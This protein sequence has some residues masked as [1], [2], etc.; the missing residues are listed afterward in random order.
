MFGFR[1]AKCFGRERMIYVAP[2]TSILDQTYEKFLKIFNQFDDGYLHLHHSSFSL[3]NKNHEEQLS[4]YLSSSNWQNPFI[5]TTSVQFFDSLFSN[6]PSTCRKL[7]NI[8]NSVILLDEIQTF[9]LKHIK[10]IITHIEFLIK[11]CNCSFVHMS[12]TQPYYNELNIFGSNKT[13]IP[14]ICRDVEGYS[15]KLERVCFSYSDKSIQFEEL[16]N[17]IDNYNQYIVVVNTKKDAVILYEQLK[18]KNKTNLFHLS[19]SMYPKHR[20]DSIKRIKLLL[21]ENKPCILISTQLIEVGV[22]IDFPIGTRILGS[23]DSIIQTAG[24]INRN[25]KSPSLPVVKILK[26][27]TTNKMSPVYASYTHQT[28]LFIKD[29]LLKNDLNWLSPATYKEYYKRLFE[30]KTSN[31]VS[32]SE[33][34]YKNC[35]GFNFKTIS[36]KFNMIDNHTVNVIIKT[37]KTLNILNTI[38]TEKKIS[39]NSMRILG[40]Y[41]VALYENKFNESINNGLIK[42]IDVGNEFIYVWVGDYNKDTG[43]I[44]DLNIDDFIL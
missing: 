36:E 27:F 13:T 33:D 29:Y 41:S 12:A 4:Y 37:D 5:L 9:P 8:C 10:S 25:G 21:E 44:T 24:R 14:E 23:Y 35:E 32:E 28:E 26:L 20:L 31:I 15:K 2:Y 19:T 3:E 6:H 43:I 39:S 17:S 11:Y 1:H 22:D 30:L 42:K 7:H 38:L 40:Q 34:I 18:L 16:A